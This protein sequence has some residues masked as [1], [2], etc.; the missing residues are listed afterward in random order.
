MRGWPALLVALA[1]SVLLAGAQ[2][3]R[4]RARGPSALR[5]YDGV[6]DLLVQ[7]HTHSRGDSSRRWAVRGLISALLAAATGSVGLEGA[8]MELNQALAMR[9][10][11]R[12]ARWYE[13]R[14][15][16]DAA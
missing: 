16:S 2:E 12:S 7:V 1:S 10:R 13:Q 4:A 5:V 3:R 6:A 14:L 15:R 11:P 9:L 8:A